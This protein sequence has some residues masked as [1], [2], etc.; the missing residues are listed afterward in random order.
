MQFVRDIKCALSVYTEARSFVRQH[1]LKPLINL[2][3]L[4]YVF[5]LTG[6]MFVLWFSMNAGFAYVTELE[7]IQQY[8]TFLER[9]PWLLTITK[10]AMFLAFFFVTLSFYKYLFLALTSPLF[11]YISERT[12]EAY[13]QKRYPFNL[14]DFLGD[15]LRGIWIS[16]RSFITQLAYTIP[17]FLFSL[18]PV[19]GILGT[20]LIALMDSYYLGF[21]MLDYSCERERKTVSQSIR[22]IRNRRGL[23]VGNGVVLYV[24]MYI[25]V[26]GVAFTAPLSAVAATLAY[27]KFIENKS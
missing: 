12:A 26:V 17:L 11:A 27:Y 9:F 25:P 6:L 2:S 8:L 20:V 15:V 10:L 22:I 13:L 21:S 1:H 3:I 16:F 19:I 4:I 14:R 5:L 24:A 23:A 18:I 7:A